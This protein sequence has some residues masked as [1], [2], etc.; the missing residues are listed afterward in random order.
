MLDELVLVGEVNFAELAFESL[1]GTIGGQRQVHL[2][3]K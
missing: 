2:R 3:T 1:Q